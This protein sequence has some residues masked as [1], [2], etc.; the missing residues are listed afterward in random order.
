M[1]AGD[2]QPPGVKN[3]TTR[4][5]CLANISKITVYIKNFQTEIPHMGDTEYLNRCGGENPQ[6]DKAKIL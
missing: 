6:K 2:T 5:L 3:P 1:L 4:E